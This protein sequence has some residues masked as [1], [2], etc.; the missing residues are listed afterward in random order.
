MVERFN[1]QRTMENYFVDFP[2][3]L[4]KGF[5]GLKKFISNHPDLFRFGDN[6]N[7]NPVVYLV[8]QEVNE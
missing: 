4:K 7:F 3:L 1:L 6:H 8:D 2:K 5:S